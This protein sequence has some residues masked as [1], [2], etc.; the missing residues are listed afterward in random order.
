[1]LIDIVT[2]TPDSMAHPSNAPATHQNLVDSGDDSDDDMPPLLDD[3][4]DDDSDE[5]IAPHKQRGFGNDWEHVLRL[6]S[7]R[8][9]NKIERISRERFYKTPERE[10]PLRL[11][12]VA[13][14]PELDLPEPELDLPELLPY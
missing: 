9:L 13:H 12:G 7:R 11:I 5:S 6:F 3:S 4:S 10:S 2:T 8:L 1:M 14:D